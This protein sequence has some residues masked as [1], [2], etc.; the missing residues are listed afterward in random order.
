[1]APTRVKATVR[2]PPPPWRA[3]AAA[4]TAA[5]V[6]KLQIPAESEGTFEIVLVPDSKLDDGRHSNNGWLQELPD[7]IT[8]LTWDNAA[9]ISPASA[10]KLAIERTVEFLH[11][12]LG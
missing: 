8:K 12:H 11:Q 1:M 3:A 9:L 5:I 2:T 6:D 10:A 7:P 4:A